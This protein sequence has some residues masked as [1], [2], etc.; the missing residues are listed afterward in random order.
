MPK[1]SCAKRSFILP[2][3]PSTLMMTVVEDMESI[4]PRK[5]RS[6]DGQW[7]SRPIS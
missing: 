7:K 3:S 4:A 1:I 5:I 2:S 6:S